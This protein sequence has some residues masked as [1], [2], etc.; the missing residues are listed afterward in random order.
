MFLPFRL[1]DLELPNRVVVS[2]MDMYTAVDG[3]VSDFHLVHLGAA[4][5]GGAGARD[6]AR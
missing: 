1:R 3:A 2:P 6:D 4:A 5:V